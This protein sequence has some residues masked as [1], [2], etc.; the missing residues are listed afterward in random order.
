M[1]SIQVSEIEGVCSPEQKAETAKALQ[2]P[3]DE[4]KLNAFVGKMLGDVGAVASAVNVI[5][6]DR[7]GLYGA[8]LDGGPQTPQQLAERTGT[9]ER[10]IC[11]WLAN[12]AAGGYVEFDP[13]SGRFNLPVE[14]AAIFVDENSPVNMCGLFD[15]LQTLFI[16]EP[17][18]TESFRSGRGVA[19]DR[20]SPA[21]FAATNRFFTPSYKA[22]LLA[23][24]L[25]A[26][27]GVEEK[28]RAGAR[29]ADVG[30]GY[31]TSTQLMARAFP[32]SQF[33]GFDYHGGSVEAAR[34]S[35]RTADLSGRVHFEV[36][37]ATDFPGG[38]YDFITCFDC[39]HDMG[40]PVGA[41]AHIRRSLSSDGTFMMVEPAANDRLEDN[42][43]PVGRIF[44]GCSSLICTP[45]SL[46]QDGAYALGAQ[47]G[48]ARLTD[49]LS[50][51]GFE[52]I[53]VA[54]QTPFH[55][56]CDGGN[57]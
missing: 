26:L 10:N 39:I 23:E 4:A 3:I 56:L 21:L 50:K 19:W 48:V 33:A 43:N 6:G 53:R 18:L 7:L 17:V 25:P 42:L 20:H 14:H 32:N 38:P 15:T 46:A 29:V 13:A 55:F 1:P 35:V 41:L 28:L 11:E 49:V 34:R 8:L 2:A 30:A 40:D 22:H 51:A 57:L 12:Q 24:W 52:K 45:A 37:S 36:A 27:T 31:G 44:Y 47:A 5:V 54:A 16:D 9:Y